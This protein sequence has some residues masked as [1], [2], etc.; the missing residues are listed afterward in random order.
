MEPIETTE[1]QN[2]PQPD[3][4]LLIEDAQAYLHEAGK[5]ARFLG[6]TNYILSG[7]V[8]FLGICVAIFGTGIHRRYSESPLQENLRPFMGILYL[9][10][11]VCCFFISHYLYRFGN[12]AR[13]G[14]EYQDPVQ[15][16][17][18]FGKLKSLFKFW[19]ILTIICLVIYGLAI[20]GIVI[21][22]AILHNR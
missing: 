11:A 2:T 20:I 22:V 17:R 13:S 14:V 8:A 7:L 3:Q 10:T 5:W 19:G 1:E 18:A 4:L 16:S 12:D 15:I 21:G 9:L 6:I